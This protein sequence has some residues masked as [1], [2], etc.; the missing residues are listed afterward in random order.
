MPVCIVIYGIHSIYVFVIYVIIN[1][2]LL[3]KLS[4]VKFDLLKDT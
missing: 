3:P 1:N 2:F 4:Y